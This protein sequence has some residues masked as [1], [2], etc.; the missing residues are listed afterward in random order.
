MKFRKLRFLYN[1]N[2]SQIIAGVYALL[3]IVGA[4]LLDLPFATVSGKSVGGLTSL[5]TSTSAVCVTGLSVVD[6]WSTFSLFGQFVILI[7]ME[8]GGLGFMSIISILFYITDKSANIRSLSLIAES[9]GTDIITDILRVQKRLLIGSFSFEFIGTVLLSIRFIPVLGVGKGIWFGI[10]HSVSAFCN[11]GFDLMGILS[12]GGSLV[13]WAH[14]PV[15]LL[16]IA[17][18]IIIGGIGFLVWNDIV[19]ARQIRKWSVYTRIVMLTTA[20]L[21]VCSTICFMCF[22]FNAS[23]FNGMTTGEKLINSFFQAATTRTAGFASVDQAG[24]TPLSVMLTMLL[25]IV[26]GSAGSTA[27][28]IKTVTLMI[29]LKT[30]VSNLTGKKTVTIFKRTIT[31]D[32]IQNA[33]T[34]AGGFLLLSVIGGFFIELTS[35][36]GLSASFFESIS[37]L[38]TVG[39]SLGVTSA[40]TLSS[41]LLLIVLM[42]IGR[43]GLLTLTIGFFK[44]KENPNIRY[45]S[46]KLMIG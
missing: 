1:L 40:L 33:F 3:I 4:I 35:A 9:L 28:G 36:A 12:P 18:L 32:Q 38:A 37:A 20:L 41:K 22:E 21:L 46:V 15:V 14:D 31:E 2:I 7:L 29:I 43:V 27:G 42:Y 11:A 34:V 17:S 24:L 30:L 25:M 8:A 16:T 39:L 23:A 10:F 26:G 6:I 44:V 45:P 5:F 19:F 13:S